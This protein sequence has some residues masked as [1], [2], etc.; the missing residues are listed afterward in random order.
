ML[1]SMGLQKV[2]H[3]S[4]TEQPQEVG[5]QIIFVTPVVFLLDSAGLT[6]TYIALSTL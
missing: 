1:Q 5:K 2:R 4:A 6:G 3:D